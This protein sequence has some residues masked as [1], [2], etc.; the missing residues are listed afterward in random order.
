MDNIDARTAVRAEFQLQ[1][2]YKATGPEIG[3]IADL[4]VE[5]FDCGETE[6][7][8]AVYGYLVAKGEL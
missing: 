5:E 2:Y 6:V 3:R 4:L 7:T 1:G 8:A